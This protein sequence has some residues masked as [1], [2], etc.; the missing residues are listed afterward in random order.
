MYI[1]IYKQILKCIHIYIIYINIYIYIYTYTQILHIII[2]MRND[3]SERVC[4]HVCEHEHDYETPACLRKHDDRAEHH[5]RGALH[6]DALWQR[7]CGG[8]LLANL[9]GESTAYREI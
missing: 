1:Y 9:N 5:W 2:I 4:E 6:D 3:M 7:Q 8:S